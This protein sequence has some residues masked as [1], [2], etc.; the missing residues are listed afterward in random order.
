M[1]KIIDPLFESKSDLDAIRMVAA[2]MGAGQYFDQAPDEYLRQIMHIGQADADPTVRGLTWEQLISEPV[3]LN[4][5]PIPYVPF[6]NKQFPLKSGKIEFYVEMLVP[7]HQELCEHQ[8]PIEASPANPLYQRYPLVF[9]VP[10][11]V[12][13]QLCSATR[14]LRAVTGTPPPDPEGAL[15]LRPVTDL[16]ALARGRQP[17]GHVA[18]SRQCS[19]CGQPVAAGVAERAVAGRL[20]AAFPAIAARLRD[21]DRCAD[22]LLLAP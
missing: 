12:V 15:S 8:E 3:H 18:P 1:P 10:V 11:A 13:P 5:D 22:C 9:E 17:A 7:F 19:A 21:S 16:A 2:K 6:Y 14:E 20:A 4:T